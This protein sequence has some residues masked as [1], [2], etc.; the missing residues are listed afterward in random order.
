MG[1]IKMAP[2][3]IS[4]EEQLKRNLDVIEREN[5]E[6]LLS[7]IRM[8]H[9][10]VGDKRVDTPE[11]DELTAPLVAAAQR[12]GL[13]EKQDADANREPAAQP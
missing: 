11:D 12:L 4:L 5:R 8:N 6:R 2:S 10:F 13:L 1:A 7:A 3:P 9:V